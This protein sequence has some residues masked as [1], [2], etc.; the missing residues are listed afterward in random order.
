[1]DEATDDGDIKSRA[2]ERT[3]DRRHISNERTLFFHPVHAALFLFVTVY[4]V[5]VWETRT[6]VVTL[7]LC[8]N[9][10]GQQQ[11]DSTAM[12]ML[13]L[14]GEDDD[15]GGEEWNAQHCCTGLGGDL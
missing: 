14:L 2:G 5:K 15:G 10:T 9:V 11:I 7:Y 12:M 1:M 13:S 3:N 8:L 4:I 6:S